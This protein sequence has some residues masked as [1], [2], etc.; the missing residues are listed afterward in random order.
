MKRIPFEYGNI[1][2][3]YSFTNRIAE[4]K[5]LY[6]NMVNNINTIIISPR[7]WGKS[8]LVARVFKDISNKNKNIKTIVIDLFTVNSEEEF[9]ELF[10]KEV[11]KASSSKW[12]EW[13]K[14]SKVFFKQLIP[15]ISFGNDPLSD[16]SIS[17]DL[18]EL[19]KS[20]DEILNLPEVIAKKK[21]KKIIIGLDEFQNLSSFKDYKILE[22]RMRSVWQRQKNVTY[23]LFGSKRHM[24]TQIFDDSS[25]PFYRF[26]DIILL[27]KISKEDWIK[28]IYKGFGKT[29]KYIENSGASLI[30]ELMKN[31]TWYVQQLA[32]YTWNLT[33]ENATKKEIKAAL[34]E[35]IFANTPF[36]QKD[37]EQLS[38]T[39][40]NLLKAVAN[41]ETKFTSTIVMEKYKLGT[42]RNVSKNKKIL[43]E[44]DII[45]NNNNKYEFLDPAFELW[46][47]EQFLNKSIFNYVNNL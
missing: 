30:A 46:F 4:R 22:K 1:V 6:S 23:C 39:Q 20:K 3:G 25:N 17:F 18:K 44:K 34:K 29:N 8:S 11:I 35:L 47:N 33:T 43:M 24:M 7:R 2:S 28:F 32:H 19:K 31:H 21:K 5:K 15:R 10:A 12:E 9:L 13:V 45:F 16:F 42:P 27:R 38:K 37:I 40:I 14:S 26:G 36:Y 41:D